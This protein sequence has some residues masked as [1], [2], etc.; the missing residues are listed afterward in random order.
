MV[1]PG[2]TV[3]TAGDWRDPFGRYRWGVQ[4][5]IAVEDLAAQWP[6]CAEHADAL[7]DAALDALDVTLNDWNL[8]IGYRGLQEG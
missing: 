4:L 3:A 6:L 8:D 5:S 2:T 1:S 7:L